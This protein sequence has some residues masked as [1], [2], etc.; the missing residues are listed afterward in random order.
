M[1]NPD[2]GKRRYHL[3]GAEKQLIAIIKRRG[4]LSPHNAGQLSDDGDITEDYS[5][6]SDARQRD[7]DHW[8]E[9]LKGT[10]HY[11]RHYNLHCH[12]T[13]PDRTNP[14]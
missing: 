6:S 12:T 5:W 7:I 13:C 8:E 10:C 3:T 1:P 14:R 9:K 11:H 4:K 2:F